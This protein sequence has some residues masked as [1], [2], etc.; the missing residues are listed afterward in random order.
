[1]P[2]PHMPEM[3]NYDVLRGEFGHMFTA[4]RSCV[5]STDIDGVFSAALM[6]HVFDWQV[7]GF[8]T[9]DKLFTHRGCLPNGSAHP[10]SALT[11]SEVVFLDHD[12]YRR[13][14]HSVGHHMLQ[15]SD[16]T[17]I[18]QHTDGGPASIPIFCAALRSRSST[19]STPSAHF[20]S[21]W[22]AQARGVGLRASNRTRISPRSFCTLTAAS[23]T[24]STTRTTGWTGSTGWV[25]ASRTRPFTPYANACFA[26]LRGKCWKDSAPWPSA[27]NPS[28]Y[29]AGLRENSKT[30]RSLN[31]GPLSS[32]SSPGS[33]KRGAGNGVCNHPIRT[34]W[35]HWTWTG[36]DVNR[37]AFS[38]SQQ[39]PGSPSLTPLLIEAAR[40]LTTTGS[41]DMLQATEEG[42]TA[43]S[44]RRRCPPCPTTNS[45]T[46]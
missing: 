17:P 26:G 41:L 37:T 9:L 8:Y 4:G 44:S 3:C 12:V 15:W 38:L 27:F 11:E 1:M 21:S 40:A 5:I 18:P 23:S 28:V 20:T 46:P 30:P 43:R 35:S 14:L 42:V 16:D 19:G 33:K 6:S 29:E 31:N 2:Y 13:D 45:P 25:E 22:P 24:R 34:R 39:S 10:E 32:A 7:V 36:E